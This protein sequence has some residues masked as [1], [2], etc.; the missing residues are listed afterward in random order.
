MDYSKGMT[1]SYYAMTVDPETWEILRRAKEI[2][3]MTDGAF[4]VTIAPVT[5]LWKISRILPSTPQDSKPLFSAPTT[6]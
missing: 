1:R 3:A 2:S 6:V 5:A 4:S